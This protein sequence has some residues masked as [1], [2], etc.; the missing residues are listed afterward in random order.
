MPTELCRPLGRKYSVNI[1]FNVNLPQ[2]LLTTPFHRSVTTLPLSRQGLTY[3]LH[4]GSF[5]TFHCLYLYTHTQYSV[6]AVFEM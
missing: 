6:Y 3:C 2:F 5:A 4:A 1:Y